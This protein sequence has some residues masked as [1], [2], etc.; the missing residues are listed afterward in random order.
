MSINNPRPS[1]DINNVEHDEIVGA[2]RVT[3]IDS[4]G[5]QIGFESQYIQRISYNADNLA[6]YI[7][8][9]IPGTLDANTKWQIRKL[10]YSGMN[11]TA[12]NFAGGSNAFS[13]SW[14]LRATYSYS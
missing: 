5:N 7:G 10:T 6:E 9:A 13:S 12:V 1:G 8:L 3:L 11:V 2:R 14:N 4:S